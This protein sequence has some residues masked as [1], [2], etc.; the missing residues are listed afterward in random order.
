MKTYALWK[1][2]NV[3]YGKKLVVIRWNP[4]YYKVPKDYIRHNRDQKL[5]MMV[6]LKKYLYLHNYPSKDQIHIYYMYYDQDNERLSKNIPYT[7][8]YDENDIEKC[9]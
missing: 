4:D 8:I 7:L 9:I 5:S 3:I 2:I 6:K 1:N